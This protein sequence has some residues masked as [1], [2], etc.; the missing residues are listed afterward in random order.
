MAVTNYQL[1][2]GQNVDSINFKLAAALDAGLKPIGAPIDVGG[3]IVQGVGADGGSVTAYKLLQATNVEQLAK[4]VAEAVVAEMQPLGGPQ[5]LGGLF[6]QAMVTGTPGGGGGGGGPVTTADI[7]DA[8]ALGRLLMKTVEGAAGP[9]IADYD[10]PLYIAGA[11]TN[12]PLYSTL[13]AAMQQFGAL[14]SKSGWKLLGDGS[15]QVVVTA[16]RGRVEFTYEN[17]EGQPIAPPDVL[18]TFMGPIRLMT[19][20]YN[21]TDSAT[22]FVE[23]DGVLALDPLDPEW[24]D[25]PILTNADGDTLQFKQDGSI[26]VEFDVDVDDPAFS[27]SQVTYTQYGVQAFLNGSPPTP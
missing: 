9:S 18:T 7:T 3:A 22:Q 2:I 21:S 27:G 25:S 15:V 16:G 26:I 19:R 1:L 12:F 10:S 13:S 14:A 20:R 6:A 24:P 11:W 4:L 17:V 8:T 23:F 5:V